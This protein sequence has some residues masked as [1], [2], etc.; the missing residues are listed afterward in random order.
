[1]RLH[2]GSEIVPL[3]A[4]GLKACDDV[5]QFLR[6]EGRSKT[7][8][9]AALTTNTTTTTTSTKTT[10]PV[11]SPANKTAEEDIFGLDLTFNPS[12]PTTWKS[13]LSADNRLTIS[14][15]PKVKRKSKSSGLT[16]RHI[17]TPLLTPDVTST[18]KELE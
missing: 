18:D 13:K 12:A 3:E 9:T 15:Y 2:T 5:F 8:S 11:T 16:Q 10:V 1:M 7:R 6:S 4:A 14:A 17:N